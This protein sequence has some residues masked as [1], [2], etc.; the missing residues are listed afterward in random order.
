MDVED[1][2]VQRNNNLAR[3]K[4]SR[5]EKRRRMDEE[6]LFLNAPFDLKRLRQEVQAMEIAE[7]RIPQIPI[8]QTEARSIIDYRITL[9]VRSLI[10][11]IIEF[12]GVSLMETVK[13]FKERILIKEG[14]PISSQRLIY[15]GKAISDSQVLDMYEYYFFDINMK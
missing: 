3:L 6:N 4:R 5:N 7:P 2:I 10:G 13:D 8:Q 9:K 1:N 12:S 14:I 15:K 11:R